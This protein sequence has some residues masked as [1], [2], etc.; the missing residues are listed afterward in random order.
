[1]LLRENEKS[2]LCRFTE[3]MHWGQIKSDRKHGEGRVPF[4]MAIIL[5]RAAAIINGITTYIQLS[6]YF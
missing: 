4:Q 2:Q 6:Q 5:N 3:S 1:M